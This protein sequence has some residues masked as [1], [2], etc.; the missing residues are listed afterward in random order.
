MHLFIY[1][2]TLS[3][4]E[5][6]IW[7]S[8]EADMHA[9]AGLTLGVLALVALTPL[10]SSGLT[11]MGRVMSMLEALEPKELG[12]IMHFFFLVSSGTTHMGRA[13]SMLG[14]LELKELGGIMDVVVDV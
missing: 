3:A 2:S 5:L 8:V 11:H 14:A 7:G 9:E 13:M 4:R 10:V 6:E 1:L 12:G